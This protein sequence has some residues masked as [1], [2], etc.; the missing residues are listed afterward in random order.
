MQHTISFNAI[1]NWIGI[2]C[3][4]I[5]HPPP[6]PIFYIFIH[7][8]GPWKIHFYFISLWNM[9]YNIFIR[10]KGEAEI[11]ISNLAFHSVLQSSRGEGW[12]GLNGREKFNNNVS[13]IWKRTHEEDT[14]FV[15]GSYGD[16]ILKGDLIKQH[17]RCRRNWHE[18]SWKWKKV[19]ELPTRE[20]HHGNGRLQLEIFSLSALRKISNSVY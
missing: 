16:G 1:T 19:E 8:D 15:K 11:K 2:E 6:I 4:Q 20:V 13:D 9:F 14:K 5:S 7:A 18:Y 17:T 3:L 12:A 10:R